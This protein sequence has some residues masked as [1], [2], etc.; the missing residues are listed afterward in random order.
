MIFFFVYSRYHEGRT[1]VRW[2]T[3]GHAPR[4]YKKI[5]VEKKI[6]FLQVKKYTVTT[7]S[8]RDGE[9]VTQD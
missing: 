4:G 8:L 9:F 6:Y 3:A 7:H 2:L 5:D 1:L